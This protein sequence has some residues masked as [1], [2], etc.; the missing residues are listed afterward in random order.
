M[1][2]A[3]ERNEML[4]T[5]SDLSKE[6]YGFRVRLDYDAMSDA[7]LQDTWDGFMRTA[8]AAFEQEKA[9]AARAK[10]I[11][12]ADIQ[13]L[14]EIGAGNRATAIRWDMEAMDAKNG[15]HFDAG[16]YCYLRGIDYSNEHEIKQLI[17]A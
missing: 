16:Y 17:A 1:L 15:E 9:Q 6:A 3:A 13:Q 14:I 4:Q 12:E 7:D 2:T 11:W 10:T 8:N 5:I